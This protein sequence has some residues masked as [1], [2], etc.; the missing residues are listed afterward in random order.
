MKG[1]SIRRRERDSD[2]NYFSLGS[3]GCPGDWRFG[4]CLDSAFDTLLGRR[5]ACACAATCVG[6]LHQPPCDA[7]KVCSGGQ[8]DLEAVDLVDHVPLLPAMAEVL[9]EQRLI[10][11]EAVWIR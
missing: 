8:G 3:H 5:M 10:S 9:D 6:T 7:P 2:D 1:S 11:S 4:Y